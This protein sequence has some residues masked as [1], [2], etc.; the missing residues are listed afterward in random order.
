VTTVRFESRPAYEFLLTLV[1]WATPQRVDSYAAGPA[2][3]ADIEGRLSPSLRDRVADLALGCDHVFARLYGI[4]VDLEPPGSAGQLVAAVAA[5]RPEAVRLTL[6]GYYARRTRRRID[7]AVIAE[8]AR[9]DREA[10]RQMIEATSD[11]PECERATARILGMGDEE[12][13]D[14]LQGILRDWEREVFRTHLEAVGSLLHDETAHLRGRLA[15][16]GPHAFLDEVTNGADVLSSPGLEEVTVF[17]TWVLRPWNVFWEQ[18]ATLLLGV[19]VAEHRLRLDPE[20]PPDRL[21]QLAKALGDERRMRVLRRLTEGNFSLQEL[22]DHFGLSKSTL[23]HHLVILR[24]AG[25]VRVEAGANGKYSLRPGMPLE[26]HRLL[27]G[28]L[29]AVRR[30]PVGSAIDERG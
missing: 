5:L 29:P 21:V 20:A 6:L 17:P 30:E 14:L 9:G 15:V 12:V 7:P 11:G 16:L 13:A 4:A 23:L 2:W 1:A 8:A 27:D 19:P 22:A 10:A 18:G 25:I 26:L 28:Y 24:S 3:F